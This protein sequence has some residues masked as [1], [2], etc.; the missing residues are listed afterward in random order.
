LGSMEPDRDVADLD[1]D[2]LAERSSCGKRK[3]DFT[4]GEG[5]IEREFRDGMITKKELK[6]YLH[7]SKLV[8]LTPSGLP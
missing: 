5:G 4:D 2:H 1:D 6:C 3:R 7:D 8:G